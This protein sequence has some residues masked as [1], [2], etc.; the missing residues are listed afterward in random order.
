MNDCIDFEWFSEITDVLVKLGWS[1]KGDRVPPQVL[2]RPDEYRPW[3]SKFG[4]PQVQLIDHLRNPPQGPEAVREP[5]L[6]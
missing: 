1:E 5:A 3:R 4:N 6:A 2:Q